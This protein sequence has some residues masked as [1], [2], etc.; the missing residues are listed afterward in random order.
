MGKYL[1]GLV[2]L[3]LVLSVVSSADALNERPIQALE[4]ERIQVWGRGTYQEAALSPDAL[5]LV[6]A[7][8]HG[9]IVI[10]GLPFYTIARVLESDVVSFQSVDWSP[11]G[12]FVVAGGH[13][14]RGGR[15]LWVWD[16]STGVPMYELPGDAR[17]IASVRWSPD[18]TLIGAVSYRNVLCLW[19]ASTGAHTKEIRLIEE[20]IDESIML[21]HIAWSPDSSAVAFASIYD[22][23]GVAYVAS[24]E[25][26]HFGG[27]LMQRG[28]YERVAWS[29]DGKLAA[30]GS[31]GVRIWEP[32]RTGQFVDAEIEPGPL[33][34]DPAWSP[35][36]MQLAAGREEIGLWERVDESRYRLIDRF[37]EASSAVKNLIWDTS[38]LRAILE[39]GTVLARD[40]ERWLQRGVLAN[41]FEAVNALDWSPD[42]TLLASVSADQQVRLWSLDSDLPRLIIPGARRVAWSPDGQLLA[43][44]SGD[45]S[46]SP[47]QITRSGHEIAGEQVLSLGGLPS[48]CSVVAWS[49]DGTRLAAAT[50]P[51]VDEVIVWNIMQDGG[52][53][54]GEDALH[55]AFPGGDNAGVTYDLAWSAD[56]R[57]IAASISHRGT[58]G[59]RI[60]VWDASTGTQLEGLDHAATRLSLAWSPGGDYL[61]VGGQS[62]REVMV[63]DFAAG[64][65][66]ELVETEEPHV[67]GVRDLCWSPD[68]RFLAGAVE[69]YDPGY[70]VNYGIAIWEPAIGGAPLHILQIQETETLSVAWHGD[71]L[72][73]GS[74]D[75]T[76]SVW[77]WRT[78]SKN[79]RRR[80]S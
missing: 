49:P 17:E 55:L 73:V 29:Q 60:H 48:A 71:R 51:E 25:V 65:S 10:Y 7:T 77:R 9:T 5:S 30:T 61:A 35:D 27:E 63:F 46:I 3:V 76:I 36:G 32:D 54:T 38:G 15:A 20:L 45:G 75:G 37:S 33:A 28:S 18:G 50:Y 56:G 79:G 16:A 8:A 14:S 52:V 43:T 12:R 69:R 58:P 11:D 57:Y 13:A 26:I 62:D 74:D 47:W 19:D 72:A 59:H 80:Q 6:V 41:H 67:S 21:N 34:G 70:Y 22:G 44:L 4:F 1:T 68:G 53:W 39:D 66:A 2:G 40:G 78:E 42:G 24:D 31:E 23:A 64:T